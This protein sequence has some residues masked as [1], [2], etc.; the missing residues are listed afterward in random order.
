MP[1]LGTRITKS[2]LKWWI[3]QGALGPPRRVRDSARTYFWGQVHNKD[4]DSR[5]ALLE[6]PEGYSLTATTAVECLQRVLRGEVETGAR[7]PGAVFGSEF[8][9]TFD[10]VSASW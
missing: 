3:R 7:T 1:A 6:T 10:G 8:I 2:L 5:S 4:Y 9:K